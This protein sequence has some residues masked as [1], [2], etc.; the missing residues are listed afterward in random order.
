MHA[1]EQQSCHIWLHSTSI[2]TSSKKGRCVYY[3]CRNKSFRPLMRVH[4][5][6]TIH[7]MCHLERTVALMWFTSEKQQA[8]HVITVPKNQTSIFL[9][10]DV[11]GEENLLGREEEQVLP[12]SILFQQYIK[13]EAL[14]CFSN[15]AGHAAHS[16]HHCIR[17]DPPS[18]NTSRTIDWYH[19]VKRV[20]GKWRIRVRERGGGKAK[21]LATRKTTLQ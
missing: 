18:R 5:S 9:R 20:W 16:V 19:Q 7:T 2:C 17:F 21:Q 1:R 10:V 15:A 13:A 3:S 11:G 8:I 12:A 6:A 4:I 14:N